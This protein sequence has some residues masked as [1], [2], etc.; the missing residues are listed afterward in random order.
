MAPDFGILRS[1]FAPGDETELAAMVLAQLTR[2]YAAYSDY[3]P[4]WGE[5]Q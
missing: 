5:V 4:A 3:D 2:P 1:G